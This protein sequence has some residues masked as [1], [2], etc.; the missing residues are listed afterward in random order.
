VI[1]LK[2][3]DIKYLILFILFS[4]VLSINEFVGYEDRSLIEIKIR[5]LGIMF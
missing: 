2:L 3:A 5:I 4:L 1:S